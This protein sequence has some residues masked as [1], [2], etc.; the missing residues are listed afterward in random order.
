MVP[1]RTRRSQ[2]RPTGGPNRRGPI[3]PARPWRCSTSASNSSGVT[4]RP[5]DPGGGGNFE[6]P[7]GDRGKAAGISTLG[8]TT[9]C[10]PPGRHVRGGAGT[11]VVGFPRG[12]R[13]ALSTRRVS[14]FRHRRGA[15]QP[16]QQVVVHHPHMVDVQQQANRGMPDIVD[17][18]QRV[19]QRVQEVPRM[20]DNRVQRLHHQCDTGARRQEPGRPAIPRLR[21]ATARRGCGATAHTPHG[22]PAAVPAVA[23]RPSASLAGAPARPRGRQDRATARQT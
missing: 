8:T 12:S 17:Q 23:A 7:P 9:C 16:I 2:G 13:E 22:P 18:P 19:W 5:R 11:G 14:F 1:V 3:I 4:H 21:P 15:G 20:I 10:A 6:A